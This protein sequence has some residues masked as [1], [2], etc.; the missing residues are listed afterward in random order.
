MNGCGKTSVLEALQKGLVNNMNSNINLKNQID[1]YQNQIKNKV[2]NQIII[3]EKSFEPKNSVKVSLLESKLR[4]QLLFNTSNEKAKFILFNY[5]TDRKLKVNKS[6]GVKDNISD[7]VE[8]FEK[9][10]AKKRTEQAF[11]S[12]ETGNAKEIKKISDWFEKLESSLKFLFEDASLKLLS[13]RTE[14]K[15]D[16]YLTSDHRDEYDF[17]KLSSGFSS[18]LYILFDMMQKM[19]NDSGSFDYTKEGIALIDEVEAHL[20]ISLQKKILQ[21]LTGFFPNV[22][23]IVTTHSPFI[24][25]SIKN[26]VIFDLETKKRYE[27]FSNYSSESILETFYT[28]DKFSDSMKAEMEKYESLLQSKNGQSKDEIKQ[29]RQK[30][31]EIPDIEISYW[32]KDMDIRH[33]EKIKHLLQ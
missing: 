4:H 22:Q 19:Q 27:D 2:Q 9:Y 12:F 16:F 29:M 8:D 26:S 17:N 15:L 33:K 3:N 6:Q 32:I 11:L 18:V 7:S 30:F 5:T 31:L 23:F 14:D 13:K 25:Q 20:H 24:L 28:M 1:Y 21:F 10:L